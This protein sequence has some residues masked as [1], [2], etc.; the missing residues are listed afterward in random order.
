MTMCE[1]GQ[2]PITEMV[3]TRYT[4]TTISTTTGLD[5]PATVVMFLARRFQTI[6][7]SVALYL[8]HGCRTGIHLVRHSQRH[9]GVA[10]HKLT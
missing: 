1:K 4:Q 8:R 10:A 9:A 7:R 3:S 6:P 5:S 2:L